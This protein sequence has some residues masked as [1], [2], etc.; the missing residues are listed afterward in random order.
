M[1]SYFVKSA[2]HEDDTRVD[3]RA[4]G[5]YGCCHHHSFF[6]V[7]VFNSFAESNQSTCQAATYQRHERDK[8]RVYEKR[9]QEVEHGSFTLLVFSSSGG[10]GKAVSVAYKSLASFLS[11]K[12]NSPYPLVMGWLRCSLGYSLLRSSLMR[13]RGSRSRSDNPDV[14]SAVDLVVAKD[15]LVT[16][17]V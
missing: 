9:I 10:M 8:R 12:W 4:A 11:D 13:L 7:R 16:N 14:P 17:D 2:K 5:F 3:I 15:H 6:D 1:V